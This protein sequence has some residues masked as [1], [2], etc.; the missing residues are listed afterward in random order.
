MSAGLTHRVT[1]DRLREISRSIPKVLI[2]TGDEDNL[3]DPSNSN[4]LA[5]KMPEAEYV[6]FEHT[7]H[8]LHLQWPE[9]YNELLE[10]VMIEGRER[11]I[12]QKSARNND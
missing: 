11:S 7:D 1:P 4:Y 6:V 9:R 2:V 8:G 3:V 12:E 5:E 10:R